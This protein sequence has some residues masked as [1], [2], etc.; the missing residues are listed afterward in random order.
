MRHKLLFLT[1][2]LG[3]LLSLSGCGSGKATVSGKVSYQGRP[4]LMGSVLMVGP[5][6]IT[7]TSNIEPD[8]SYKIEGVTS[9][10]VQIGVISPKPIA[11]TRGDPESSR[12]RRT[13]SGASPRN[14]PPPPAELS[15]W[16]EIPAKYEEPTT[17]G[18]SREIKSGNNPDVNIDLP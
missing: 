3:S 4:I 13:V 7:F 11:A 16:F 12:P 1:A 14:L 15:K 18:I 6:G 9:G 10:V 5:D 17:S 8:G 2:A